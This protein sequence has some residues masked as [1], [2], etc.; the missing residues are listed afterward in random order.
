M[1]LQLTI[2]INILN[3]GGQATK[4]IENMYDLGQ[5]HESLFA[6]SLELEFH[7]LKGLQLD[8]NQIYLTSRSATS[9]I[10]NKPIYSVSNESKNESHIG[11]GYLSN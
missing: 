3:F 6:D 7:L 2:S 10:I 11:F 1:A 4:I 5:L 9:N 8:V